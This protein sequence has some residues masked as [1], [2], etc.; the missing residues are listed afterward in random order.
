MLDSVAQF[1]H[2]GMLYHILV[3]ISLGST[4]VIIG[5]ILSENRNP[6]KSLAW[7]TILL[8]LPV[9]GLILYLFFGRNIKNRRMISRR[10]RRRLRRQNIHRGSNPAQAELS[11]GSVQLASMA[12]SLSGGQ[13]YASNSVDVFTDGPEMFRALCRDLESARHTINIESYIFADDNTGMHIAGILA[14]KVAEGVT[15]RLLYDHVGSFTTSGSFFKNLRKRGVEVHPF[16]KVTFPLL[17]T[18]VN[19][20]NHRKIITIDDTVAYIGGMNVAERY[21]GKGPRPW[22]DTH[23]RVAG[24]VIEELRFAFSVDWHFT[25]GA[26]PQPSPFNPALVPGKTATHGVGATLLTSGPTD[27]WSNIAMTLHRAIAGAHSRIYIQ[28]PYLLPSEALMQA[29]AGA[30]LAKVDVRIMLPRRCDSRLLSFASASYISECLRAGIKIYFYEEGMLHAKTIVVDD[31]LASVG[32]AN[33]DFRSFDYNF[34]ANLFLYSRDLNSRLADAFTADLAK[35][36]RILP[37]QWQA[38]PFSH[39]VTESILRLLSPIL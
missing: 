16:F 15:V 12:R 5:V 22:R 6:V 1:I 36:T 28:S 25:C 39:K 3:W 19:W 35:C 38:R 29:L 20:R 23:L 26:M 34:E 17:G 24:P 37:R 10:N 18:H 4:V 21:R 13:F 30:A 11:P 27:Q 7:V 9:V 32:S 14:R 31:E 8:L 2:S 33:F